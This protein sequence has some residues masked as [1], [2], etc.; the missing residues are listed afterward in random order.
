M[1]EEKQGWFVEERA[2]ALVHLTRRA[3]FSQ[4]TVKAS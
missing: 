3:F 4:T 2:R 1:S